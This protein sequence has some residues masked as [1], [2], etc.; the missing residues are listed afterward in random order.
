M[1]RVQKT[2]HTIRPVIAAKRIKN[3]SRVPV[4]AAPRLFL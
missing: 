3:V 4:A 2:E 1:R